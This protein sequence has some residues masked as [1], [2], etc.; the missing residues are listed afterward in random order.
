MGAIAHFAHRERNAWIDRGRGNTGKVSEMTDARP[1]SPDQ[2][3]LT[4]KPD[5]VVSTLAI[6]VLFGLFFAS[7][8]PFD[9]IDAPIGPRMAYW[10]VTMVVGGLLIKAVEFV[11]DRVW[12]INHRILRALVLAVAVTP[13]QTLVVMFSGILIFPNPLGPTLYFALLP[14]VWIISLAVVAILELLHLSLSRRSASALAEG[15]RLIGGMPEALVR[16]LPA[17][18]RT[19]TLFA[20]QAEDHYVRI[21]TENG[22][23][24]ILMRFSDAVAEVEKTMK[25]FRLHRSWWASEDGLVSVSY[26]RGTGEATLKGDLKAPVSRTYAKSLKDAGWF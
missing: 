10:L 25:G 15:E 21:H 1:S 24:L 12:P 11:L 19:A 26:K 9:T 6:M 13:F 23:T 4:F 8:G 5:G 3:R 2:R 18:L 16:H 7:I 20:L 14:A 22:S 17:K